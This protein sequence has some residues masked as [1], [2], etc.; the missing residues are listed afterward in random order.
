MRKVRKEIPIFSE[1]YIKEI[2]RLYGDVYDD[3]IE[4]S[5]PPA[6]GKKNGKTDY[7]GAGVDWTPGTQARHKSL[8]A[9][10][11]ELDEVHGIRLSTSKIRKIL[12]TGGVWTTERS[13]E[14]QMMFDQLTDP[15]NNSEAMSEDEAVL[16]ISRQ[17]DV[18][19]VTV[20][21]NLPYRK[22]VNRLE[23]KTKNAVRCDRYRR[24]K[25]GVQQT[26]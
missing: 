26:E 19:T 3:R 18:S 9:F 14:I 8:A 4:D 10:R 2:C 5:R 21:I 13:R 22:C 6:A 1:Q 25:K 12:I 23:E 24:K 17:L 15:E 16:E 7:R 20:I 11:R